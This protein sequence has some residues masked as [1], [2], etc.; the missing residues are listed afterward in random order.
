MCSSLEC[1]CT[2]QVYRSWPDR[3]KGEEWGL[4][5][6]PIRNCE[7]GIWTMSH[8][9]HTF[10]HTVPIGLD[11]VRVPI[12]PLVCL[13]LFPFKVDHFCLRQHSHSCFWVRR[14]PWLYFYAPDPDIA[15]RMNAGVCML[16]YNLYIYVGTEISKSKLT[17]YL[18]QVIT[19]L[20]NY[21]S[22]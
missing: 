20:W 22:V 5:F 21:F 16:G 10:L 17:G 8:W 15:V 2:V 14:D 19:I 9:V 7:Q 18:I 11:R 4:L 6:F 3:P 1:P 13:I 12:L